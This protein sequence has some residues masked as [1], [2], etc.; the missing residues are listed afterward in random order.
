LP[1]SSSRRSALGERYFESVTRSDVHPIHAGLRTLPAT[2][3]DVVNTVGSR[4]L[5]E[6]PLA[7]QLA[8]ELRYGE[9]LQLEEVA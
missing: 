6:L 4:Y 7:V 5:R 3:N 2:A 8:F 9:E 1:S